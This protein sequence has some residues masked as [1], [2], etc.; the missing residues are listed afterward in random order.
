MAGIVEPRPAPGVTLPDRLIKIIMW[1][2]TVG[3][4]PDVGPPIGDT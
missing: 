3:V 4:T 2:I 1:S